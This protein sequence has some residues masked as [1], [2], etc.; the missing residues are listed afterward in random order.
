[1]QSLTDAEPSHVVIMGCGR[2]GASVAIALSEQECLIYILDINR[3]S[4]DRLPSGLTN[5]GRIIPIVGDGT[6]AIE[7]RKT[8]A[9]DAQLFIAVS[10]RDTRNALAAQLAKHIFQVPTVICR[11]NDPV[12]KEMY[13]QLG[14]ISISAT[15]LFTSMVL[16]AIPN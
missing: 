13:S 1:M 10:G 12:R 4:F 7:L 15:N 11:M 9:Q 6:L 5:S 16:G 2:L 14:L 3:E 8:S